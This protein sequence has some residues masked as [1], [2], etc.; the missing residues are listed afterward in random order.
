MSSCVMF[1][2]EFEFLKEYRGANR[3]E[4]I[5][6]YQTHVQVCTVSKKKNS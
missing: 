5:F 2:S 3:I 1:V 6:S 4:G